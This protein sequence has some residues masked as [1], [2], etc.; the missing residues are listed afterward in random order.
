MKAYHF[1]Q[2]NMT[3]GCGDEKAWEVGEKRTIANPSEIV[4]CRFGYHSSPSLWDA[5]SYAPG[6]MACLVEISKP[7]QADNTPNQRKAVSISRTLIKAVNID[8]E[9]RLFAC[10]CAE[11]VL[12]IYERDNSG[13]ALREAIEVAR[14]FA[15]G[16]ATKKELAAARETAWETARAAARA[17]AWDAARDAPRAAWAAARDAASDAEA[18]W[19]LEHFNQMFGSIF[20]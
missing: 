16:K 1:L 14:R 2:E 4:L 6:P 15:N 5:L 9:L 12:H 18:K 11:R 20:A 3:A 10:D 7:I 19:Q 17:A 13:K 8:C